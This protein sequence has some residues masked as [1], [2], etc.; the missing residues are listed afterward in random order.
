MG[1][2]PQRH[3]QGSCPSGNFLADIADPDQAKRLPANFVAFEIPS[4]PFFQLSWL[5]RLL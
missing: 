4:F 1:H 2:R 3:A 5:Q